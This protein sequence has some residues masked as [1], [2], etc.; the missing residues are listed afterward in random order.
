MKKLSVE[1][2]KSLADIL[3]NIA[4]AW[5]TIGVISPIFIKPESIVKLLIFI[6]A[7]LLMTAVFT[8]VSLIVVKGEK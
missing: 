6:F 8:S 7:G 4:S 5:F 1:Q 2:R 3:G